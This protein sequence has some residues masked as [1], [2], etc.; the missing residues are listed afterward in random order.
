M[1]RLRNGGSNF[2]SEEADE[3]NIERTGSSDEFGVDERKANN[4]VIR[5]KVQ[6]IFYGQCWQYLFYADQLKMSALGG[7]PLKADSKRNSLILLALHIPTS[8]NTYKS[9][10]FVLGL[11]SP[12]ASHP[13]I[14]CGCHKR[15]TACRGRDNNG[16]GTDPH[17]R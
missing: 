6:T 1:R 4:Y 10:C 13:N 3:S 14:G 11:A 7:F 9:I 2:P 5:K 8:P 17:T 16:S 15:S 12:P